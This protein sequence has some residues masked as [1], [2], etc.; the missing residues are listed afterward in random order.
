MRQKHNEE[1][2]VDRPEFG[3]GL[4]ARLEHARLLARDR[5]KGGRERLVAPD[6][7]GR[8]VLLPTLT[9]VQGGGVDDP[10]ESD[11][12]DYLVDLGRKV[13]GRENLDLEHSRAIGLLSRDLARTLGLG[14]E[15]AG[16]AYLAG[17]FHDLGKIELSEALLRKPG[18]LD[19]REWAEMASHAE[20]GAHLVDRI[21]GLSDVAS[22]VVSH[23]ERWDGDGYPHRIAGSDIPV[24]A[25]IVAAS[26]AFVTMTSDRPFRGAMSLTSALMEVL[27]NSGSGFDPEVV[28]ALLGL[29]FERRLTPN[30]EAGGVEA[31]LAAG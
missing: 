20:R 17:L 11:A 8:S 23:H 29:A 28:S 19:H 31:T 5:T 4:R 1:A 26:D 14:E 7:F 27:R 9:V 13:D 18:P 2:V 10:L 6:S 15:V 24:E 22:I 16:R 21:G 25:R 12:F 3:T 30:P